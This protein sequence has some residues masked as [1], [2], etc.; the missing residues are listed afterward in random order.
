MLAGSEG[1][2]SQV[3][4][5]SEKGVRGRYIMIIKRRK[6][7]AAVTLIEAMVA[8]TILAVAV[9]GASGYRY[10]AMLDARKASM[11]RTAAAIALSLCENWRGRGFDHTADYDP[12][13]YLSPELDIR[14]WGSG[15]A[16]PAGFTQLPTPGGRCQIIV[17]GVYYWA[18]LSWKDDAATPGLR[19]LNVVIAWQ[20]AGTASEITTY[21]ADAK[22]FKLTTYVS[23]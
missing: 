9:L 15:P 22:T 16:V 1:S 2:F 6:V 4:K 5:D 21:S 13:T 8:M 20:Q 7:A 11:Q 18:T 14:V 3:W 10:Y 23:N 19:A 17:E 12:V